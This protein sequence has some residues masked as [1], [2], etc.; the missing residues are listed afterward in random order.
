MENWRFSYF[1]KS[2]M[3]P[4]QLYTDRQS[5]NFNL[6]YLLDIEQLEKFIRNTQPDI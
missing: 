4:S 6:D 3:L 1:C 5:Q 2:G